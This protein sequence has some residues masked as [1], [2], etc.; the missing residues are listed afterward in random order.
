MPITQSA[1]K[2]LRSSKKKRLYNIKRKDEMRGIIKEVKKLV[3]SQ[4]K[5]EAEALL[6]KAFKVLDKAAKGNTI[7]KGNASRKKARLSALVSKLT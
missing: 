1:K 4:K 5:K 7:K 2:A 3:A 6:S